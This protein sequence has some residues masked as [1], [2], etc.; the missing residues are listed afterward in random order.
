MKNI[1]L[2]E[3][4]HQALDTW[5]R[6]KFRNLA[7]VHLDSHIDFS[8]Y[9]AK[10]F[11]QI[12]EEAHNFKDLKRQ[13]ELTLLYKKFQNNLE[14]QLNIGNYIYPALRDGIMDDF[15]WVVPGDKRVFRSSRGNI[16]RIIKNIKTSDPYRHK[17]IKIT[18]NKILTKI[19]KKNF[20]ASDIFSLP[21]IKKPILL[22]LD[23]DFLLFDSIKDTLL[24]K[25]I[26]ERKPW[27]YPDKLVELLREKFP[28][29]AFI[30]IAYSVNGGFTPI[31]YKFLGDEIQLRLSNGSLDKHLERIFTLRN[32]AIDRY[33]KDEL[34]DAHLLFKV[35][36]RISENLQKNNVKAKLLAHLYF[37]LFKISWEMQKKQAAKRYYQKV[38]HYDPTYRV[39][40]NNFA[41]LYLEKGDLKSAIKEFGKIIY[42]DPQDAFAHCGLAD[43]NFRLKKYKLAEKGY[44]KAISLNPKHKAALLGLASTLIKLNK[45]KQAERLLF[46]LRDLEPVNANRYI[47]EA[48]LSKKRGNFQQ[49]LSLYKKAVLLGIGDIRTFE[50]IFQLLKKEK[51][52]SLS[53]FFIQK[54]KAL[55]NNFYR[56]QKKKDIRSKDLDKAFKRVD[57]I[58]AD[59]DYKIS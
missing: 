6:L 7:L 23:V 53:N 34:Q 57:K 50:T 4:H 18:D 16:K 19:N 37:W 13:I 26:G 41:W 38:I 48:Q 11:P 5:R 21:K 56:K 2:I 49:A 3:D 25:D 45:L 30:T 42:C 39:R 46:R 15:F 47:L 20:M 8:F 51:D 32:R 54:Y 27:I 28:K 1:T 40:D 22:D 58:I 24:T 14:A 33:F 17:N 59:Y 35:A 36:V 9:Q 29:A 55:K 12:L 43:I 31:E 10:P 52:R 44:K